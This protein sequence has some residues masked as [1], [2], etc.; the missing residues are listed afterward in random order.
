MLVLT[1]QITGNAIGFSE[2]KSSIMGI[3]LIIFGIVGFFVYNLFKK[4][5]L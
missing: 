3:F 5:K 1:P 4:D 2:E